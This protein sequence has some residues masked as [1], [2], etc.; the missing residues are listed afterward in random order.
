MSHKLTLLW[1]S[2]KCPL[3]DWILEIFSPLVDGEVFDGEHKIVLDNC[4]VVD[5]F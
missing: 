4:L 3:R 5:S 2:T 1:Q